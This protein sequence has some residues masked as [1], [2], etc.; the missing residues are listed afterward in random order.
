MAEFVKKTLVGY[1]EV[2]G[3]QGD[4]ECT[5]VILT[6][7]EYRKI[8]SDLN[9]AK[10]EKRETIEKANRAIQNAKAAANEEIKNIQE[11]AA[12]QVKKI[13]S[14]LE[15]ERT[16]SNYQRKL[17]ENLLR[18]SR[19]RANT[20]RKLK[21]KKEHTGYVVCSSSERDYTYKMGKRSHKVVLWETVLQSPYPIDFTEK[22]ARQQITRELFGK[23]ENDRMFVNAIGIEYFYPDGLA[24]LFESAEW[25]EVYKTD[26]IVVEIK[27]RMNFRQGYWE[28]LLFHNKPLSCVPKDM[29]MC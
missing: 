26:N 15:A 23:D 3:G 9:L 1:K 11:E 6:E 29:R 19:E 4:P 8:V 27:L 28:I 24:D 5:H 16:E 18:I 21:P 2:Q 17:N 25:F 22:Q 13:S 7:K 20:D 10:S 14:M 12:A